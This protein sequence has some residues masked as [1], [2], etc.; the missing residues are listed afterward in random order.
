MWEVGPLLAQASHATAAVNHIYNAHPNTVSYLTNLQNMHTVTLSVKTAGAL[1]SLAESLK[2][3]NKLYY[4]WIENPEN[5]PTCLATVAYEPD[6]IRPFLKKCS[7]YK[8][9]STRKEEEVTV[10]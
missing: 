4:L 2:A 7:L 8:Y 10:E 1:V 5:I 9:K 3:N 6:E